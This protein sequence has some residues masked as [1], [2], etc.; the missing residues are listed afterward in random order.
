MIDLT[1]GWKH[2]VEERYQKFIQSKAESIT[3]FGEDIFEHRSGF[4]RTVKDLFKSG[5]IGGTLITAKKPAAAQ[6]HQVPDNYFSPLT[7]VYSEQYHFFLEDGSLIALRYFQTETLEHY[8]AWWSDTQG[9]CRELINTS[10]HIGSAKHILF[11]KDN[12]SG[13]IC[14]P[15]ANLEIQFEVTTQVNWD[16]LAEENHRAVIHQPQLL[17]TVDTNQGIQKATGYCKIY[18]GNYPKFWGYH[19]VDAF[20]PDY[21]IVWS[22]D[23]TFGQE[24]YN[25]FKLLSTCQTKEPILLQGENS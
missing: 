4:Y 21:G 17:C 7:R 23:A 6:I 1:T 2:W 25:Y 11:Q 18:Q 8:S 3:I 20:F 16:V 5:K 24:K 22:A 10:E 15:E 9:N 14:L 19:F 12:N 13:K